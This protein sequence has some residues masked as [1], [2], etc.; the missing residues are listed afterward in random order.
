MMKLRRIY[1]LSEVLTE[2]INKD[3]LCWIPSPSSAVQRA[4][5]VETTCQVSIKTIIYD[6]N[7]IHKFDSGAD[8]LDS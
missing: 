6:G 2:N 7:T 3:G 1:L 5:H 4:S 8:V